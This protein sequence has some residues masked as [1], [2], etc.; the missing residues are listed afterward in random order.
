MYTCISLS[1]YMYIY[2]YREIFIGYIAV[3]YITSV[4]LLKVGGGRPGAPVPGLSV[5]R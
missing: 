5:Y 4:R 3:Y 2:I 1:L